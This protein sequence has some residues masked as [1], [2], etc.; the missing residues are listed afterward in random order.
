MYVFYSIY[1]IIPKIIHGNYIF[2]V[3]IINRI[4]C[5][6]LSFQELQIIFLNG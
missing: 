1:A 4:K 2:G 5:S 6:E 3:V